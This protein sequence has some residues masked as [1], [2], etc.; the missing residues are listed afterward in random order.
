MKRK[1]KLV[2]YV[3]KNREGWFG[4]ITVQYVC[5]QIK[6][7]DSDPRSQ[8]YYFRILKKIMETDPGFWILEIQNNIMYFSQKDPNQT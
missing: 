1:R 4:I 6:I 8:Q 3:S 5:I 7:A 2:F